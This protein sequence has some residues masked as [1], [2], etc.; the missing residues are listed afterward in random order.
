MLNNFNQFLF[1]YASRSNLYHL[2]D[3]EKMYFILKNNK[4]KPY[5]FSNISTTRNKMMNSYIGDSSDT[6]FKLEL[7]GDK[8]SE[9][10]KIVPYAYPSTEIGY[11]GDRKRV[12]LTEYEETIKTQEINNIK[13]YL[14]KIII[15]KVNVERL[16]NSDWFTSDRIRT[17]NKNMPEIFAELIPQLKEKFGDIIYVQEGSVIKKNDKYIDDIINYPIKQI[18]HGYAL[19]YR[20]DIQTYNDRYH[21]YTVKDTIFPLD[22]RNKKMEEFVIGY[23]YDNL[24][25][26]KKQI[27]KKDLDKYEKGLYE[28]DYIY[29]L[30]DVIEETDEYI[31]VK[32][33]KI[34][35]IDRLTY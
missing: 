4:L 21:G 34:I 1:E 2:I 16:K 14:N 29:N 8:I 19:Y 26:N 5:K 35:D 12:Y 33:A 10:Y 31:Y 30:K 13:K 3:I 9:N 15:V 17:F 28:F 6:I 22:E 24:Y 7:D 20:K 25:L 27:D 32:K 23:K 18:H 11:H